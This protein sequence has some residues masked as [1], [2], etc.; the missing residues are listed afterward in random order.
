MAANQT[1]MI[2]IIDDDI[3]GSQLL[4]NILSENYQ[5]IRID[6]GHKA[7][8]MLKE[9]KPDIILMDLELPDINGYELCRTIKTDIYNGTIPLIMLTDP[10]NEDNKT[11]AIEAGADDLLSKPVDILELTTRVRSL[12]RIKELSEELLKERD[13]AQK[14]IDVVGSIIG[15]LDTNMTITLVNQRACEVLGYTKEEAIG[16]NWFDI[17]LPDS[18]RSLIK[19]AYTEV[20]KGNMELPE[21]SEKPIL[22]KSGEER[23][24]L[25]HDVVLKD[26][27]GKIVGT[28]S[29]G[30]DIT[31]RKMAEM[32]MEEANEQLTS[33]DR[34]KNQFLTNL[35]HELRTPLV[36]I[37]GFSEL[38]Y[39]ERI[40]SLS[41]KQ[42]D[43]LDAVMR[44]TERLRYIVDSLLYV[45]S[46]RIHRIKYELTQID[47][48]EVIDEVIQTIG[49]RIARSGIGFEIDIKENVPLI[50]GDQEHLKRL[51]NHLLDNAMKFTSSGGKV[52]LVVR[53][54]EPDKLMIRVT[55]TGIGISPDQMP[56]IFNNFYQVDGSTKRKYGGTGVGLHICKK[57]VEA[58]NGNIY[59]ES[60]VNKGTTFTVILPVQHGPGISND[61]SEAS[62]SQLLLPN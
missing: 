62:S 22:T 11:K 31:D 17:F 4:E 34:M 36:S 7:I 61:V 40:G 39:E 8:E 27:D 43:A 24:I 2:W 18:V 44:N 49:P 55:D 42:R 57:I 52:S 50:A 51:V 25:W 6:A 26:D 54:N 41:D 10:S 9:D 53:V 37:K 12:L 19:G 28:I 46:D 3:A 35:N 20:L 14:Y 23:L 45:S 56:N 60:E 59:A 29:S 21:F 15:V 16:Q 33:L 48:I 32:A 13:L 47:I 1:Q 30:D 58:H 38:L 5:V